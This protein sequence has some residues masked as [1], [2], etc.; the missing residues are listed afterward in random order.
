[1]TQHEI[2]KSIV[3]LRQRLHRNRANWSARK[4]LAVRSEMA[5][6][7]KQLKIKIAKNEDPKSNNTKTRSNKTHT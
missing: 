2:K 5:F 7:R 4:K 6:L 1:M 3:R